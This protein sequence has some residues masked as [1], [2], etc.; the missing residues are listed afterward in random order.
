MVEI[1]EQ[2]ER[3]RKS[4]AHLRRKGLIS[5]YESERVIKQIEVSDIALREVQMMKDTFESDER[6]LGEHVR[7]FVK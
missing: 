4:I 6:V 1:T 7:R 2:R 5:E 3:I